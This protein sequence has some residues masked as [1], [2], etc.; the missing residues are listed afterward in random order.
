MNHSVD[1]NGLIRLFV[2]HRPVYPIS[3]Q[4]KRGISTTGLGSVAGDPGEK[5]LVSKMTSHSIAY[6]MV[7][8][9]SL[10]LSHPMRKTFLENSSSQRVA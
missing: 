6:G 4:V 7:W 9:G 1:L 3:K 5:I 2:N 8:G 10:K